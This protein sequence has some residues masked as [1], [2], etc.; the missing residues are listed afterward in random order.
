[1]LLLT[2]T[3]NTTL[4]ET[5]YSFLTQQNDII[6]LA[7]SIFGSLGTLITIITNFFVYRK[8]LKIRITE[9]F[10]LIDRKQLY[11]K[12]LFENRSRLPISITSICFLLNKQAIKPTK[13]TYCVHDYKNKDNG[14]IVDR[15]FTYNCF[16]SIK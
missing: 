9:A 7:L 2:T 12:F 8:N 13:S 4:H 11:V 1:M 15:I 16:R 10:Y 14:Q 6:T 5:V 3:P